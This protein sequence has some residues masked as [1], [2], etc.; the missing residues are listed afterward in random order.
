[1]L[2]LSRKL[3]ESIVIGDNIVI[4][5]VSIDNGAVKLGIEAPKDI[6]IIRDELIQEVK[7]SNIAAV[8]KMDES[9]ISELSKLLGK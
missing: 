9:T 4:K 7:K 3:D 1:M 6:S 5:V 8:H 2:V